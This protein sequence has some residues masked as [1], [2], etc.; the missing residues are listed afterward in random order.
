MNINKK[1]QEDYQNA[2]KEL[3]IAYVLHHMNEIEGVRNVFKVKDALEKLQKEFN[4]KK[5]EYE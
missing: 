4:I 5:N 3:N 1:I 2:I